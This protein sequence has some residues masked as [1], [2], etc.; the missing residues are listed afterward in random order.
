[1]T[2][3]DQASVSEAHNFI[4][5]R[6]FY[7]LTYTQRE[8]KDTKSYRVSPNSTSVLSLSEPGFFSAYLS[9]K[10]CCVQYLLALEACGHFM[11]LF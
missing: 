1:M 2:R 6:N 4:F 7:T 5:Q 8:M 3:E 9:H 11:T 10:Q